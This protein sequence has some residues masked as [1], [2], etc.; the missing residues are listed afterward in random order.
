ML[1]LRGYARYRAEHGLPG[2]S[3]AAVQRALS[4]GRIQAQDGKIDPERADAAWLDNTRPSMQRAPKTPPPEI[5]DF[6]RGACWIA[7]DLAATVRAAWPELVAGMNFKTVPEECRMAE[8]AVLTAL[9][10]HLIEEWLSE[11]LDLNRLPAIDWQVFGGDAAQIQMECAALRN[12]WKLNPAAS[13]GTKGAHD[14]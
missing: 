4:D 3:L 11:Y 2:Q 1:S 7:Q 9:L 5:S 14:R 10:L 6:E 12:E 13:S 8:R